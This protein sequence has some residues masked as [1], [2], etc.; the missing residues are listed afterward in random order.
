V[1]YVIEDRRPT[2][3]P[4]KVVPVGMIAWPMN[5]RDG[6]CARVDTALAGAATARGDDEARERGTK[7]S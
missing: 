2:V 4:A 3:L 1:S 5:W 7:P 6:W